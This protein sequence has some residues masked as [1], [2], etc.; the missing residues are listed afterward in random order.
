MSEETHNKLED[1]LREHFTDERS[2]AI[3]TDYLITMAGVSL[4][5]N[6]PTTEY[7]WD[8]S[9]GPPHAT[10]GLAQTAFDYQSNRFF[11]VDEDDEEED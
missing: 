8:C 2:G 6:E 7:I 4:K 11:E 5:A 3:L 9:S 1:A 10:L